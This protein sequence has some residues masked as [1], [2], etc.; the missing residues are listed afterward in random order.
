MIFLAAILLR[1][2][3]DIKFTHTVWGLLLLGSL[4]ILFTFM[5]DY[6]SLLIQNGYWKEIAHVLHNPDFIKLASSYLP[7]EYNWGVFWAGETFIG[8]GIVQ[9]LKQVK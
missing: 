5:Q 3:V 8:L 6:G 7:N 1:D 9:L 4:L 2:K